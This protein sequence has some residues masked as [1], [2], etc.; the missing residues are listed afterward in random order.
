MIIAVDFDGVI[1][2]YDEW[3]G[4][5]IFGK[6]VEGVAVGLIYLRANGH[7][8][9]VYTC[10]SEID[11]VEKY[12]KVHEIPYDFI[13]HCPEN[14]KNNLHPAKQYADVYIDD[15]GIRFEGKWDNDF[16]NA[17]INFKPWGKKKGE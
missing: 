10:R 13:N 15:R 3:K 17:V 6:P 11:D 9:M 16:L 4:R 5:G 2:N 1:A 14:D 12:L 8:I 7:K